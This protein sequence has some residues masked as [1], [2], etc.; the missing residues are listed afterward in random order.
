MF[1]KW[2]QSSNIPSLVFVLKK[3]SFILLNKRN[4]NLCEHNMP[5]V[6]AVSLVQILGA[7]SLT[8]KELKRLFRLFTLEPPAVRVNCLHPDSHISS[9]LTTLLPLSLR[10]ILKPKVGELLLKAL[11]YMALHRVINGGPKAYF[12]FSGT[13]SVRSLSLS[14]SLC[15]C[16]CDGYAMCLGCEKSWPGHYDRKAF[17]ATSFLFNLTYFH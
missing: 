14:L 6:K 7:H 9:T 10:L 11:Q 8:V 13:T 4:S 2:L 15:V 17:K 5:A 12:S 1:Q 3:F 16:V